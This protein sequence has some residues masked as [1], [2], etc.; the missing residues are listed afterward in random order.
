MTMPHLRC[1]VLIAGL[2]TAAAGSAGAQD[3]PAEFESFR[4]PGWSFTPGVTIGTMRDSNV[5]LSS[6]PADTRKTESDTLVVVE[7]T[8]QLGYTSPRTDFAGGYRGYVRRYL[9]LGELNGIDHRGYLSLRRLVT[10][11]LSYFAANEYAQLPTTD[12]LLLNGVPFARNGARTN[13]LSGGLEARLTK[14]D[15]LTVRYDNTW[16][17]FDGKNAFLR[18]GIVNG[19]RSELNHHVTESLAFGAE[20][21]L[22]VAD[23]NEGTEKLTFQDAGGAM[24][25]KRAHSSLTLA[26]GLAFLQDRSRN[27]SNSGP[28]F[29]AELTEET[30]RANV[31][32]AYEHSFVPSFGFGG[33]NRNDEVRGSIRMP[34]DRN[35]IYVQGTA[36]WRR[37]RPFE[38]ASL[39]LDTTWLHST[40]GYATSR[41]LRLEGYYAFSRQDTRIAGG[42]INR[43]VAGAQMVVSQP[44]RIH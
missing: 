18:G 3:A 28:Y 8:V 19:V 15:T 23:L 42:G 26:G 12:Q 16:V 22:R 40:L 13:G 35:R 29:R 31:A 1:A 30:R 34:L 14:L 41:W 7:P 5:A 2:L 37:S 25:A 6:A 10:R 4:T 38:S 27:V 24:H 33:S 36:L 20:Y 32:V 9:D 17:R 44:M 39:Q 11:R 21:G 43:H